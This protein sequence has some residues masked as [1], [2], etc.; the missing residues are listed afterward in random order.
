[1]KVFFY[2]ANRDEK[3]DRFQ[4]ELELVI[5]KRDIKCSRTKQGLHNVLHHSAMP[6]DI[7]ILHVSGASEL[8]DLYQFQ[9]FLKDTFLI[10]ILPDRSKNLV[11]IA[12]RF[13]PRLVSYCDADDIEF[14]MFVKTIV[15]LKNKSA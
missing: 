13:R 6:Y 15:S 5:P 9:D 14:M 7:V 11:S 1:M 2:S 8:G 12:Y 4:R 3:L 10:I